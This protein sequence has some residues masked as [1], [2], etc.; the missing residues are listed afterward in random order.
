MISKIGTKILTWH[1]SPKAA[2]SCIQR[3]EWEAE[4]EKDKWYPGMLQVSVSVSA[5]TWQQKG[6]LCLG[7]LRSH[8][9]IFFPRLQTQNL[10]YKT[11]SFSRVKSQEKNIHGI[12]GCSTEADPKGAKWCWRTMAADLIGNF[13]LENPNSSFNMSGEDK[14]WRE[15]RKHPL[16]FTLQNQTKHPLYPQ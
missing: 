11:L 16:E 10:L 7:L 5:I 3:K 1:I 13:V 9:S 12:Q 8:H 4:P 15:E 2:K 14:P 6:A